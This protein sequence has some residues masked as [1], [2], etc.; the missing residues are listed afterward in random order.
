[1]LNERWPV[2]TSYDQEHLARIGFPLGGIGTGTI[3]LGG[4]GNLFDW[5]VMNRPQKGFTPSYSFFALWDQ[6]QGGEAVTRVLEGIFTPPYDGASGLADP[7]GAGLPRF[8]QATFHAAYPLAQLELAD[9]SVPVTVRLEAF[10]PMIPGDSDRSGLPIAVL[11]WVLRNPGS[12]PVAV[13]VA[14]SVENFIGAGSPVTLVNSHRVGDGFAGVFLNSTGGDREGRDIGTVALVAAGEGTYRTA[15]HCPGGWNTHI[16]AFWDDFSADG[17]LQDPAGDPPR[18]EGRP[19]ASV[20]R[21]L[22]LAPGAEASITFLLAWHFPNRTAAGCGWQTAAPDDPGVVGNY[23]TTQFADAW[24][25]AARL[26]PQIPQLEADTVRF[27]TSFCESD[28][29]QAVKEAALNNLSTLRTQTCFRTADGNFFGFEGCQDQAGCC[30]GSC[31][32][33]WNYEQATPFLY[34][35]LARSMRRVELSCSTTD[36]GVNSFRTVLPLA[37]ARHLGKVAADGQMGVVMK[38][39]REWRLSGDADFLAELW[40]KAKAALAFAWLPG[41]WDA[42]QDG[43]MEGI[44][45]NTYDVEFF[46]PNPLSGVY[47]L[48]ALRA[49]EEMA[50]AMDDTP[51]AARC[52]DLFTRGSAWMDAH[53]FNGEY[54]IQELRLLPPGETPR[55]E[56]TVGYGAADQ[57]RPDFQM[58]SG[59]LVDQLVGQY[60][61]HVLGL[62]YLLNPDHV[63]Q[64]LASIFRYNFRDPLYDHWNTMRTYALNDE[65]ALLIASY[66]RGGRPERP[67]PYFT[68]VMTGFEYQAAAHMIYEGLEQEGLRV[69]EAIRA[70][71]DGRK[72]SPWDEAECGHH[73][74]RAMASW[75]AVLALTGFRWDG[76]EQTLTFAPRTRAERTRVFWSIGSAWGTY[77]QQRLPDGWQVELAVLGGSLTLRRLVVNEAPPEVFAPPRVLPAGETLVATFPG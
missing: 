56:L 38:L 51:F 43:V 39:Y 28:L 15:W 10:N 19:H 50:R 61:A 76:V 66:P 37:N 74:A 57:A 72:R 8:R 29:P 34:P 71:Y 3:S 59:C 27:V 54:Y 46:G 2:L 30:F 48:G 16:L 62:G 41:S 17:A 14:G 20:A 33:V 40:P 65:A 70:R 55:P 69:I 24:D 25:V 47:Y 60:L 32:H 1:M 45:H 58:G 23:Y 11:R 44:Q 9:P 73:Y 4:R 52:R 68:E 35:D 53:L 13:A 42:D 77:R 75:A 67:F 63:R 36:E 12:V 5:E 6:P 49:A 18:G 31:T 64:T 22:M 7:A 21:K 26:F